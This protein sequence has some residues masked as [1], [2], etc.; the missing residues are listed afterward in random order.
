MKFYRPTLLSGLNYSRFRHFSGQRHSVW[1]L[2]FQLLSKPS[3]YQTCC[4]AHC[5]L[6]KPFLISDQIYIKSWEA[7]L[8]QCEKKLEPMDREKAMMLKSAGDFR[9][10]LDELQKEFMDESSIQV[11]L[12]LYPVVGNYEIFATFFVSMMDDAVE[13][14]MMWGLLYL[15][16]RVKIDA[17]FL[18]RTNIPANGRQLALESNGMIEKINR[19][20]KEISHKLKLLYECSQSL[21]HYD[22]VKGDTVG[23]HCEVITLWLNIIMTF[24]AQAQTERELDVCKWCCRSLTTT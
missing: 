14:S 7:T 10:E 12:L 6:I 23:I 16:V 22:D 2:E 4:S 19:I 9:R 11:I 17:F 3:A 21:E 13:V 1:I 15:V 8:G 24:R 18:N 20:L 5:L